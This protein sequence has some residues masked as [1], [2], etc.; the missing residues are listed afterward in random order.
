MIVWKILNFAKITK[1]NNSHRQGGGDANNRIILLESNNN[2]SVLIYYL[3]FA[4]FCTGKIN[5]VIL[6]SRQGG[7]NGPYTIFET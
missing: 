4:L 5:N 7:E 6:I 1:K 3:W 2:Y